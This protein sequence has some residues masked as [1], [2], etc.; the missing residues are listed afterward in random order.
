[1]ASM[2]KNQP[3]NW[4]EPFI[5][6]SESVGA[7]IHI[8]VLRLALSTNSSKDCHRI[9]P[10]IEEKRV[11]PHLEIRKITPQ[12]SYNESKPHPLIGCQIRGRDQLGVFAKKKILKNTDLGEYVGEIHLWNGLST[13]VGMGTG[14]NWIIGWESQSTWCIDARKI[15]NELAFVNDY[16][17]LKDAP[18][19]RPKWMI[20]RGYYY[21]GYAA[22]RDIQTN[23]EIVI[24]YGKEWA[25][26]YH[27]HFMMSK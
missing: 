12:L 15:A 4:P 2:K 14:Y 7:D 16:R 11:H 1:M 10:C 9:I 24:D 17:G 25:H 6:S 23:E 3:K 20:H 18:N 26:L 13:L 8:A 5:Y 22:L 27:Q 21:F 19:V